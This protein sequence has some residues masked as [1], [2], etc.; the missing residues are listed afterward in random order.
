MPEIP[1]EGW[2]ACVDYCLQSLLN[3][4][5]KNVS[6]IYDKKKKKKRPKHSAQKTQI[7]TCFQ[8]KLRNTYWHDD[9]YTLSE[10]RRFMFCWRESYRGTIGHWQEGV[11]VSIQLSSVQIKSS[12]AVWKEREIVLLTKQVVLKSGGTKARCCDHESTAK[13]KANTVAANTAGI[14]SSSPTMIILL[15]QMYSTLLYLG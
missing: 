6:T 5:C 14:L 1:D 3:V 2:K 7:D 13:N 9:I 4:V 8:E 12:V 15:W 11:N 10:K